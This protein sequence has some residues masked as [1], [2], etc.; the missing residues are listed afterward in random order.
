MIQTARLTLVPATI[1]LARAEI[2]DRG[3]FARLLDASVPGNWPL[4]TLVDALPLLP[5]RLQPRRSG[6]TRLR[7]VCWRRR[8]PLASG[9]LPIRAPRGLSLWS[10]SE[11]ANNVL[12]PTARAEARPIEFHC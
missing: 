8:G 4:A 6:R 10:A 12:H 2:D 7:C 5:V 9:P 1:A 3:E 11:P